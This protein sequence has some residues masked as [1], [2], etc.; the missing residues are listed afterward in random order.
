MRLLSQM[1]SSFRGVSGSLSVRSSPSFYLPS[2]LS[3]S[4]PRLLPN[5]RPS[6]L[7]DTHKHGQTRSLS[8]SSARPRPSSTTR[9]SLCSFSA[10]TST[11]VFSFF[12]YLIVAARPLFGGRGT[13]GR[14]SRDHPVHGPRA[15]L[16]NACNGCCDAA[17]DTLL[18]NVMYGGETIAHTFASA[19]DPFRPISR[20]PHEQNRSERCSDTPNTLCL[21]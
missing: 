16:Y 6:T 20:E 19:N 5:S 10:L 18:P 13:N 3:R 12:S 8:L 11:S 4:S 21:T 2:S 1:H 14:G 9:R 15:I 17:R 7:H